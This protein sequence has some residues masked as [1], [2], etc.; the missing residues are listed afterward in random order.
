[1]K[2]PISVSLSIIIILH[3]TL[4]AQKYIKTDE[5][6]VT[7]IKNFLKISSEISKIRQSRLISIEEFNKMSQEKDTIILDSRSAKSFKEIHLKGAINVNFSDFTEA[8]LKKVIPNKKTKILIYCNNN[9]ISKISSLIDKS[10]PLA[11]NIPTFINLHEYGYE[12]VY[13][14]KDRIPDVDDRV[15]LVGEIKFNKQEEAN[16]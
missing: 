1:M 3:S 14:L 16:K 4:F 15:E 6:Q 13:E 9:F 2:N 5:S 11:L 12:N 8:K 10:L 7:D